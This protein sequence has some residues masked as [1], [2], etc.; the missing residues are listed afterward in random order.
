[1]STQ[2]THVMKNSIILFIGFFL[3]A[4]NV[5]ALLPFKYDWIKIKSEHF[6]VLIDKDYKDYGLLVSKKAEEAFISL[7]LL[8]SKHPKNTFIIIDHTKN[9]SNGSATN[10]P[11]PII[12]LQPITPPPSQSI[13]QYEDWLYELLVHE[14]THIL[15]FHNVKGIYRPLRF[16][17][18][19][20]ISPGNFMPLW[21]LEGLAVNTESFLSTGGRLRSSRYQ[22]LSKTL[23]ESNIAYANEQDT[24]VFPFGSAPYVYGG[25]I[26]QNAATKS[27]LKKSAIKNLKSIHSTFSQ[28]VPYLVNSGFKVTNKISASKSFKNV[29]SKN[30][31]K[32]LDKGFAVGEFPQWNNY[33]KALFFMQE[34]EWSRNQIFKFKD[35][36]KSLLFEFIE[37][38]YFK[39]S[40]NKIYFITSDQENQDRRIY[41]L[42]TYDLK[43][44]KI[45]KISSGLNIHNFDILGDKILFVRKSIDTQEIVLS[46]LTSIEKLNKIS[47]PLSKNKDEQVLFKSNGQERLDLPNFKNSKEVVFTYKKPKQK[48][49][50]LLLN[51]KT[52]EKRVVSSYQHI[53]FIDIFKNTVYFT[54]EDEGNKY[55]SRLNL[56]GKEANASLAVKQGLLSFDIKSKN[57]FYAS[58]I[59][60]KGPEIKELSLSK[61]KTKSKALSI[62]NYAPD[63]TAVQENKSLEVK[64]YSSFVKLK[65]HYI[66]PS[67]TFA[68]YGF[69]GNLLYGLQIGSQDPLDFNS[70]SATVFTDTITNAP[71]A[72]FSY[73]SK[74]SRRP[75]SLSVSHLNTPLSLNLI[76][77]TNNLSLGSSYTFNT[78][79]GQSF[80]FSG[81]LSYSQV[82]NNSESSDSP[83]DEDQPEIDFSD[84]L[85]RAGAYLNLD[86][87][88]FQVKNRELAPQKGYKLRLSTAYFTALDQDF[89]GYQNVK[90]GARKYFKSPLFSSHRL[91]F[92]IDGQWNNKPLLGGLRTLLASNSVNQLYRSSSLGGFTLRGLPTGAFLSTEWYSVAHLEYRFPLFKVNWG[93]GLI[94]A[95][96]NRVTAAFTADY[97]V[98]K[99]FD[100]ISRDFIDENTR[101]YSAGGEIVFDGKALYHVP[102]S[103][104]LGLYK[105]LNTEVHDLPPELFINFVFTGL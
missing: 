51:L 84:T 41:N 19:N 20:S 98:Q 48:E 42:R 15:S 62:K 7:S 97:G 4:Q 89:F 80:T 56:T 47:D 57:Q 82:L 22:S 35:N 70:Y 85:L 50:I 58:L 54:Y 88:N 1:M 23:Q 11:Y 37:I 45:N 18:G 8:S 16:I 92:G 39:V 53:N 102:V 28:R 65:P 96:F 3:W 59:G 77:T 10:F 44:K 32:S 25:W 17:L 33:H 12:R 94:P 64:D 71:S 101:L 66:V 55:L 103:F 79:L 73:T 46:S 67:L 75:L 86:I 63:L 26:H 69:T 36:K 43:T 91:I 74:H 52:Q 104:H 76:R 83:E 61:L 68:P 100:F 5:F 105:F 24:G 78:N 14:Y 6:T 40:K 2:G 34:D 31:P 93:P 60:V 72:S 27:P 99:G 29:F 49:E 81:G 38:V 21:Y 90:F 95:F 13:G 87:R 30:R 9:F